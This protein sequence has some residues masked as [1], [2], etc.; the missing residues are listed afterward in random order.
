MV[1]EFCKILRV[2]SL[3]LPLGLASLLLGVSRQRVSVLVR[4]RRLVVVRYGGQKLVT[5]ASVHRF[6]RD[7][8]R[9]KGCETRLNCA[10]RDKC[11]CC[12]SVNFS[13]S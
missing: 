11:G 7:R 12:H 1:T 10:F 13:R 9:E 8:K 6:V 3:L 4:A 5:L 2:H